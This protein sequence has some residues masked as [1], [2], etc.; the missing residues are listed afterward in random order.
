MVDQRVEIVVTRLGR[1]AGVRCVEALS[2]L[3]RNAS[4]RNDFPY[5]EW[6]VD[7]VSLD[8]AAGLKE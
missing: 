2:R 5:G 6:A 3:S 8:C 1:Y 7:R 4:G